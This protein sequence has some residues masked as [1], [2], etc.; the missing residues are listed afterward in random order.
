MAD[1]GVADGVQRDVEVF[2][3]LLQRQPGLVESPGLVEAAVDKALTS[4]ESASFDDV[5]R[6]WCDTPQTAR[7]ATRRLTRAQSGQVGCPGRTRYLEWWAEFALCPSIRRLRSVEW[8]PQ[9][10][11]P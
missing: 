8:S 4:G 5:Q 11:R 6:S 3:H 1:E 7:R 2:A 10:R 9:F